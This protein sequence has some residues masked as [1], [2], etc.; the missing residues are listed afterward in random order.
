VAGDLDAEKL[1]ALRQWA[2]GLQVDARP[3]VSAAGKAILLLVEEVENLHVLVWDKRLY[4][5][6]VEPDSTDSADP[7]ADASETPYHTLR[8][9]LFRRRGEDASPQAERPPGDAFHS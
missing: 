4:P 8:Q 2:T 5:S 3:E 6:P 1:A 9:K 7:T